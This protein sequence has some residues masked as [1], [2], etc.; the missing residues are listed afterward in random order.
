MSYELRRLRL[1]G[2]IK[3]LPKIHRYRLTERGLRTAMF[4]TR[5]YSSV[6]R[7]GLAIVTPSAAPAANSPLQRTFRAAENA[8]HPWCNNAKIAA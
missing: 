6:L 1:H 3:R 5:V 2:L 8:V 4:Y 7:P